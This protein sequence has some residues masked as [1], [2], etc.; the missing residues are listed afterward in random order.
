MPSEH[1]P[2]MPTRSRSEHT[3]SEVVGA[4]M[5]NPRWG[6][7]FLFRKAV[8]ASPALQERLRDTGTCGE[9]SGIINDYLRFNVR[10]IVSAELERTP[11]REAAQAV[12]E[13]LFH[14]TED[15]LATYLAA[16]T[17]DKGEFLLGESELA[18]VAGGT[19]VADQTTT[20]DCSYGEGCNSCGCS[21]SVVCI[22]TSK[23]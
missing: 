9:L 6:P 2:K 19:S 21:S 14:V 4:R 7:L 10:V 18:M 16:N 17:N 8:L 23:K 20:N 12:F 3:T 13:E 22:C 15:D 1:D 5:P 11:V